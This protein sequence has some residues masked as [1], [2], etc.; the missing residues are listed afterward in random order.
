MPEALITARGL[1]KTFK[2]TRALDG[3]DCD[4]ARGE[5]LVVIGQSGSGKSTLI[6]CLNGLIRPDAGNIAVDGVRI[7]THSD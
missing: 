4:V 2:A 1:V 3:V 5:K 7:D 6:R